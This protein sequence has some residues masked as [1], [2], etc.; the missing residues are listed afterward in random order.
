MSNDNDVNAIEMDLNEANTKIEMMKSSERLLKS[1]DFN[2]VFTKGYFEA[3][4]V[5][6]V[7]LK[8]DP[9][10]QSEADQAD[11][12]KKIDAIG[13]LRSYLSTV[14]MLG[15]MAQGAVE[16]YQTELEELRAEG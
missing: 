6:L 11:I 15:N 1:P 7:L 8:A 2:K 5:R 12:I 16:D 13:C 4:A 9:S 3:E 10:M 14:F